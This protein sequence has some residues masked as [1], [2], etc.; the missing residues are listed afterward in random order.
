M[1]RALSFRPR[2]NQFNQMAGK[3]GGRRPG[4][5][6]KPGP[7]SK[8]KRELAEMARDHAEAA[9]MTLV[10]IAQ[11]GGAPHSARVSAAS[12]V[13]DRGYGKPP[14]FSTSDH[15]AFK[16]ATELTD[17]E[18]ADIASRGSAGAAKAPVGTTV[19]H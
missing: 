2:N 17:D 18:L 10:N 19:T 14:Q 11:D 7:V 1:W 16:R 5:G 9:L 4:A 12:A 6:R 13:L 8:A 3:N 15:A